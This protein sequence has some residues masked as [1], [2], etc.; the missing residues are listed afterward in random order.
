[1][2]RRRVLFGAAAL[3]LGSAV[4]IGRSLA[5]EAGDTLTP[6]VSEQVLGD[7]GAPVTIIEYFSLT[8]PHCAA[9]HADTLPTLKEHFID[10]GQAKLVLRDFPLDQNALI[11]SVIAHCAGPDRYFPFIEALFA[12]QERWARAADT[13]VSL[14]QLAGLFDLPREQ[15]EACLADDAMHDAVLQSRLDGQEQHQVSE[16]PTFVVNGEVVT[17]NRPF[18]QLGAMIEAAQP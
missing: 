18:D 12:T 1:M 13:R 8:C 3:A 15:A 7:P 17:G 4:P 5:Q 16:T 6:T 9:F 10:T 2:E 11:A 14:I